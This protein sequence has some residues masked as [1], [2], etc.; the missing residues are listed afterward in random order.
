MNRQ[1]RKPPVFSEGNQCFAIIEKVSEF[2][3]R[4]DCLLM[5]RMLKRKKGRPYWNLLLTEEYTSLI[6]VTMLTFRRLVRVGF[7]LLR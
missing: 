1:R 4:L 2:W 5:A 6:C 7:V 3:G